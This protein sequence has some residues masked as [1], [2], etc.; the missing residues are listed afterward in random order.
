MWD[1]NGVRDYPLGNSERHFPKEG[2]ISLKS[3]LLM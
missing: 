1:G 2:S 3:L